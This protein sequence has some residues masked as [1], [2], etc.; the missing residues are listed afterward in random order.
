MRWVRDSNP[1]TP[2]ETSCFQDKCDRPLRQLT[3]F[4]GKLSCYEIQNRL[5]LELA[6]RFPYFSN[7]HYS[8]LDFVIHLERY[9]EIGHPVLGAESGISPLL[10]SWFCGNCVRMGRLELPRDEPTSPS[11]WPGYHYST[12]AYLSCFYQFRLV[13]DLLYYYTKV[14][15][16][17]QILCKIFCPDGWIRTSEAN[18]EPYESSPIPTSGTSGYLQG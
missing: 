4:N 11:N 8:L 15:P 6:V 14:M 1:R 5:L 10:L 7:Y 16:N 12:S 13:K 3:D 17:K 2:S 18:A 9:W